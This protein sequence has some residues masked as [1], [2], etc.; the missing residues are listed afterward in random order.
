LAFCI[1][2]TGNVKTSSTQI[3]FYKFEGPYFLVFISDTELNSLL[4]KFQIN[5]YN[6]A[7]IK[8]GKMDACGKNLLHKSSQIW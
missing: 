6:K 5:S 2:V 7:K 3:H 4:C 1:D 8:V